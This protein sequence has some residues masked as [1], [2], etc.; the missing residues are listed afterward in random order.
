MPDLLRGTSA[1]GDAEVARPGAALSRLPTWLA[2]WILALV[3]FVTARGFLLLAEINPSASPVWPPSGIALAALLLGGRKLWPGVFL[4]ALAANLAN[5]SPLP[6]AILIG[7]GNTLEAVAGAWL[8]ERFAAGAHAF[9]TVRNAALFALVAFFVATPLSA[10][11][12][13]GALLAGGLPLAVVP[14]VWLN[15]WLGDAVGALI[16]TPVLLLV[17]RAGRHPAIQRRWAESVSVTL[18]MLVAGVGSYFQLPAGQHPD[19]STLQAQF[20]LAAQYSLIP[21]LIWA[22]V[23]FGPRG[24]SWTMLWLTAVGIATAMAGNG[25]LSIYSQQDRLVILDV[26]ICAFALILFLLGGLVWERWDAG[27]RVRDER[28]RTA[29]ILA[30]TLEATQD[31]ILIVDRA[32]RTSSA[33]AQF[34]KMWRI[35]PDLLASGDDDRMLAH[36]LDQLEDPEA[37]RAR[38]QDLYAH[39]EASSFEMLPFKDGRLFER[40]SKPQVVDG[41]PVG[42]VWSFRD[43]TTRHQAEEAVKATA[44]DYRTLAENSPDLISRFDRD[45]KRLYANRAVEAVMGESRTR[46]IGGQPGTSAHVEAPAAARSALIEAMDRVFATGELVRLSNEIPLADGDHHYD[47]RV[48]PELD[49]AGKVATVL[50]LSHDITDQVKARRAAAD[51]QKRLQ[52]AVAIARLG[53]WEWDVPANKIVWSPQLVAMFGADPEHPPADY[54]AYLA[55]LHPED[56][57]M[58]DARV[59]KAYAD[60]KPY[61]VDHRILRPDG[62]VRFIH[63]DGQVFQDPTGKVVRMAGTAQDVTEVVEAKRALEK[64]VARFNEAEAATGRGTWEWDILHDKAVWSESMYLLFGVHPS[65]FVNNNENFLAMILPEDHAALAKAMGDALASPGPFLQQYRLRRPDGSIRHIRGEGDCIVEADGKVTRMFGSVQ[66]VTERVAQER[67]FEGLL[68]GA[69]DAIVIA[70]DKGAITIVNSQVEKLFGYAR[71]DLIGQPI[72][73]LVPEAARTRH[74]GHRTHYAA[75][76]H[77]RPMG[78]GM[79]LKGRRK[80]GVEIPVEVSL[81][82]VQTPE[83][84]LV[85]SSIRDVTERRKAQSALRDAKEAAERAA[86][87]K[88]D[89]LANMSHEI[90]TPLNAVLGMAQLLMGARLDEHAQDLVRVIHTSGEH[91][92]T[93][94]NDILD[95]SKMESGN[96]ELAQAP[97]DP[98]GL[99][100]DTV[101]MISPRAAE[102][103]L[104]VVLDPAGDPQPFVGDAGRLRQVLLNLLSNAVKFTDQGRVFVRVRGVRRADGTVRTTFAVED[105]GIGIPAERLGQ[106]FQPF[107]Q[108]DASNTRA[109]GGT[110]LGLAISQRLV[111]LM[112]GQITVESA[113]GKGS[114]FTFTVDAPSATLPAVAQPAL[115]AVP[116]ARNLRILL[117]EDNPVNRKVALAM[118]D[119]LG[120]RADIVANGQEAVEAVQAKPY[121]VVLMDVQMPVLDG[122][123]ATRRIH[124]QKGAQS[125]FIVA[126]T[127][128]ALPGDK[129]KCLAAGMDYY[130]AKPIRL[131]ALS[132]VLS[133]RG[134]P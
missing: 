31:G 102:R 11:I 26:S 6:V 107:R 117:A 86:Q 8:L 43:V 74:V 54:A 70:N 105:S 2:A 60:G 96:L 34:A 22:A 27:V 78:A 63:S 19:V 125:P 51:S 21:A 64:T 1:P 20:V 72:E 130:I 119:R 24:A 111:G 88:A 89:F 4:G 91:L 94:I 41:R 40:Y 124:A 87:A 127:A 76:R 73:L 56:R 25:A 48:V 47:S 69:P 121:D 10:T 9:R 50:V 123:E 67:R 122:L 80:D 36:V 109:H 44:A 97:L 133:G 75:E 118:M 132:E 92:L 61:V 32:G 49:A 100:R 114:T 126:M 65:T 62:A 28:A 71:G 98:L 12:G 45:H 106:L 37:F 93:V 15:W 66:D 90:R 3:Y 17:G 99:A 131:E 128:G 115:G 59:Q 110:G 129:E 112:G 68:E 38:V 81:S 18:L 104:E 95:L 33:N 116:P 57:A 5:G 85:V 77:A 79:E 103:G 30:A 134:G 13:V 35:P 29:S 52:E 7:A 120:Y 14:Q 55:L 84:L 58:V 39:P 83:G 42:R 16:V 46:L 113:V 101:R 23:R 108:L 53:S 82:P